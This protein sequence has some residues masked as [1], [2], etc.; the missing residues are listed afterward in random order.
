M[1]KEGSKP[2]DEA[3]DELKDHI[4]SWIMS[5]KDRFESREAGR[6]SAL[7]YGIGIL[8]SRDFEPTPKG[9]QDLMDFI[10]K[11]FKEVFL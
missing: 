9:M 8:R 11:C 2:V 4:R 5:M 10:D 3:P 1:R 7:K 6:R